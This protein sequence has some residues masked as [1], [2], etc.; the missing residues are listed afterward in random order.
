MTSPP[1]IVIARPPRR[2]RMPPKAARLTEEP[3]P[4]R[5]VVALSPQRIARLRRHYVER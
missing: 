3:P 5:V 2:I 1:R 4:P